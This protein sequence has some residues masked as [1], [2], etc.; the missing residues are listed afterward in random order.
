LNGLLALKLVAEKKSFTAAAEELRVSSPAISKMITQLEKKMKIPLLS[1]TTRSVSLTEAGKNFLEEAGPAI[2]QILSAQENARNLAKKPSGV[3]RINMPAIFYPA[4]LAP[5]INSFVKKYPDV[6]VDI[7]S[8]DQSSDIF[9][10][11]F[12]AGIRHSDILAKDMVALKLFGPIRFVTVATPKYLKEMG[13]PKHPKDL[14]GH[15]CIRHRF[16]NGSHI[17]D[18]WEFEE[19]G[20]EFEVRVSG[21]LIFNDALL[22]RHAALDNA[23]IMYTAYEIVKDLIKEKKLEIILNSFHVES[24]GYYLYFP[25]KSQVSPKLRAFIEHFKELRAKL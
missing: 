20:K 2:D 7:Y 3:L 9:E 18:K 6:S 8:Q 14:L 10:D 5:Y 21:S 1:R 11:G 12:D 23:G 16:G 15:N 22:I 19:K 13:T 25:N 24:E 4:Y 17:Y